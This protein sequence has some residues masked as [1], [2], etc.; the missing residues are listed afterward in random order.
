MLKYRDYLLLILVAACGA[1]GA[2]WSAPAALPIGSCPVFPDDNVWNTPVD[3]LPVDSHS[4]MYIGSIG[5]DRWL[6]PD[7]GRGATSGIPFNVASSDDP[8]VAVQVPPDES[9][10]DPAPIPANPLIEG[11]EDAHLLVIDSSACRLY[12]FFAARRLPGGGWSAASAAYFDLR[13]NALRP[14]GWTSADAAGLPIFP[15]LVRYEEVAAGE[16]KHAIRF[17]AP[18][19]RRHYVWP[20][21]HYAS[22]D[23]NPAL[24]PM[25]LRV[26]LRA[27]VDISAFST[28]TQ[29][30]LR[31]LKKYGM[32]LAD[33]GSP[34]FITGAPNSNW[35][36]GRMAQEM[37]QINGSSFEAV[38]VAS[39]MK[40]PN[41]GAVIQP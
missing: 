2:S 40:G 41:T 7:F 8:K 6:H 32:V 22:R 37:R 28:E 19:T 12:E 14:D 31:A 29:V 33:N 9:D 18:K 20:A 34:W 21:R 35:N 4:A 5:A 10:V 23:T 39:L 24:P 13:S 30:I 16:I 38:E 1:S 25:G 26:R 27:D 15:G 3:R 17:T 36:A 11:G